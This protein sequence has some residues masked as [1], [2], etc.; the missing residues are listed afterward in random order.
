VQ[1]GQPEKG[2]AVPVLYSGH[3][4]G[5][6]D[7]VFIA[8]TSH[9]DG[10]NNDEFLDAVHNLI[11]DGYY[12]KKDT[13]RNAGRLFLRNQ[14]VLNFWVAL[15][16]GTNLGFSQIKAPTNWST[17]YNFADAGVLIHKLSQQDGS[18]MGQRI[19]TINVAATGDV[20]ATSLLLHE[21][22]H[23]PFGLD[24][25]YCC[26]YACT[27]KCDGSYGQADP[28]PNVYYSQQACLD[29][30]LAKGVIGACEQI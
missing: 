20:P 24:D 22:G 14:E 15:D 16:Q 4:G 25:E 11:R 5:S 8:N 9:Y 19:F 10:A 2:R 30:K 13:H 26:S 29:D 27:N 3:R 21:T 23:L 6:I 7:I 18:E 1:I 17:D 28:Y 12:G